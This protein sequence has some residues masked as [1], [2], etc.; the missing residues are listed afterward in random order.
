MRCLRQAEKW[1]SVRP[2][3][4]AL[5]AI[6]GMACAAHVVTTLAGRSLHSLTFQLNVSAF[7]GIG[8]VCR[9]YVGGD[10]GVFRGRYG[11]L[12]GVQGI[13]CVRNGSG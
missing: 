8:G 3:L 12:G 4:G 7:C 13:L 9:D 2:W 5:P 6:F 10:L 11:I 1:T